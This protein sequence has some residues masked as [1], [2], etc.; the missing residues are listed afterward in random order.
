MAIQFEKK[1]Q[2]DIE[3]CINAIS[4][5]IFIGK[6]IGGRHECNIFPVTL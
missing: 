5:Y 4:Y 1:N 6:L 2:N 3:L